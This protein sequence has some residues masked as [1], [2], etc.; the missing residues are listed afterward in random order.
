ML[1]DYIHLLDVRV[2]VE[3]DLLEL[4]GVRIWENWKNC[5]RN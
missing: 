3:L 2:E 1:N 5:G 4:V